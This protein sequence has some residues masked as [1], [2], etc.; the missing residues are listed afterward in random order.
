MYIGKLSQEYSTPPPELPYQ[1]TRCRYIHVGTRWYKQGSSLIQ[2]DCPTLRSTIHCDS[3]H[4][5]L[6]NQD[7]ERPERAPP[8]LKT[9]RMCMSD[10]LRLATRPFCVSRAR[11]V[12][13]SAAGRLFARTS[14][15]SQLPTGTAHRYALFARTSLASQLPA[16]KTRRYALLASHQRLVKQRCSCSTA[17]QYTLLATHQRLFP[18]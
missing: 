12:S 8:L 10:D 11:H 6:Y 16:C 15:A 7:A 17:G 1:S 18:C 13:T 4:H 9:A 5:H 3:F 14:L 2:I